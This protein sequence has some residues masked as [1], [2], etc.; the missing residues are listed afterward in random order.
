MNQMTQGVELLTLSLQNM[1]ETGPTLQNIGASIAAIG[2]IA[3]GSAKQEVAAIDKQIKAEQKQNKRKLN[4]T[5][6]Q[7]IN[8]T[9]KK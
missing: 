5:A 2:Q 4:G 3:A 6:I 1:G 9:C 7:H 8:S